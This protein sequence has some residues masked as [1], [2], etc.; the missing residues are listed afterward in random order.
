MSGE[1]HKVEEHGHGGGGHGGGHEDHIHPEPTSFVSKYIFSHDHKIIAIQFLL[2]S[3]WFLFIGG[4]MALLLRY[5]S[6]IR[7]SRYR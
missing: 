3:M 1:T 2:V 6:P 7:S 4:G 5:R